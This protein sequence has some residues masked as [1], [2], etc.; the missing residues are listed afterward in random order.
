[1]NSIIFS[2]KKIV[3]TF[4]RAK[5]LPIVFGCSYCPLFFATLPWAQVKTLEKLFEPEAI[6]TL[7]IAAVIGCILAFFLFYVSGLSFKAYGEIQKRKTRSTTDTSLEA[8]VREEVAILTNSEKDLQRISSSLSGIFH[9]ELKKKVFENQ[10]ELSEKYEKI[11]REKSKSEEIVHKKYQRVLTEKQSTEAVIRSIAEGLVVVDAKGKVIMMNP[12]AE[13]LLGTKQDEKVGKPIAE[14]LQQEQLVTMAHGTDE[15][16]NKEIELSG[17]DETKKILRS[18]SAV[19]EDENGQTVGMVSVLSDI[20]KQ[21]ELDALKEQ[22]VASISHELRTP[23]VSTEKCI[24]MLLNSESQGLNATQQEFLSMAERNIQRLSILI[25]D[26]LDLSKLEAGRMK[27]SPEPH[28]LSETIDEV[29]TSLKT[30]AETKSIRLEKQIRGNLPK[31]SYDPNRII[32]VLNNLVGN[33][34][35]FTPKNGEILILAE[36]G[37]GEVIVRVQDT[38][39]GIPREDL[40]K[41]FDKFYQTGERAPTDIGGTGLGLSISKELVELHGGKIWAES[42]KG[43]GTTFNFTL[44][45]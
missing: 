8:A 40:E 5:S 17:E 19:I 38:G 32:Q 12:A 15:R 45:Q 44:P 37:T 3:R 10:L 24:H 28:D 39:I 34:I 25:N 7:S 27:I 20:T 4:Q 41:I 21:K 6:T 2:P 35:K 33:A 16:G 30:W 14:G 26:L 42:E 11:I 9:S 18:S 1:M 31:V 29:I 43:K 23:L 22:F 36:R 13:H